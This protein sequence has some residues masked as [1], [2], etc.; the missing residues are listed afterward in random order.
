MKQDEKQI[1][2]SD[3]V[4]ELGKAHIFLNKSSLLNN[5]THEGNS[6]WTQIP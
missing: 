3:Q 6:I 4:V 5:V 1:I 2:V